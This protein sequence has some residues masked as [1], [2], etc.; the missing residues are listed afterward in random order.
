MPIVFSLMITMAFKLVRCSKSSFCYT[1]GFF[2][3]HMMFASEQRF[4]ICMGT[5]DHGLNF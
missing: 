2:F 5:V 4:Y 1:V 3:L